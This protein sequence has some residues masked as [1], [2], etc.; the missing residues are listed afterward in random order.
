MYI[1]IYRIYIYIYIY[2]CIYIYVYTVYI[3]IY[4][5]IYIYILILPYV[6]HIFFLRLHIFIT[7]ELNF[8]SK[9]HDLVLERFCEI[10]PNYIIQSN[11]HKLHKQ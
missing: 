1:C 8:W 7:V 6:N 11:L 5:F 2:V 10:D 3:Y 9:K 4:I